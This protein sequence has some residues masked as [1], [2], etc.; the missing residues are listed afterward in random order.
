LEYV[1]SLVSSNSWISLERGEFEK[2]TYLLSHKLI[3]LFGD[4]MN[5]K[6][7]FIALSDVEQRFKR[8]HYK[9]YLDGEGNNDKFEFEDILG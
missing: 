7:N 8:I 6:I 5:S 1:L 9:S 2:I 4:Y 3:N